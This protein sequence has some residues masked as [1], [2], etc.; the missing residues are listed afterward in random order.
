[1]PIM[2]PIADLLGIQR[3]VA[4][5]AYQMGDGLS[6]IVWPTGFAAIMA[7]L[8]NVKLEKWWKFIFPI[9]FAMI[10]VQAIMLVI[11]VLTGFGA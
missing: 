6:N 5:L 8:A 10:G 4:V 11:A 1:M 2:A 9:F 7:G 3:D